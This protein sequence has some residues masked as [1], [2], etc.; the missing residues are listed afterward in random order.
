MYESR[1]SDLPGINCIW[2]AIAEDDGVFTD[3]ANEYWGLAFTKHADGIFSAELIGP[4]LMPRKLDSYRGEEYWGVEFK[5]HI[6]MRDIDKAAILGDMVQLPVRENMVC[7]HGKD[8]A[9]PLYDGLEALTDQLIRDGCIEANAHIL[10]SLKGSGAGFSER[11]WQRHFKRVTGITK[12]QIKQLERSRYAFFL[13]QQGMSAAV[14]ATEAGYA[15]QAHM[16]RSLKLIRSE[17]PAQ[18]IAQHVA[19]L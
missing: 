6:V 3:P 5:A 16:T 19:R 18:I 13:L 8:Y 9:I 17:T 12:K 11:S 2:H 4:T 7:L 1:S 10:Q 15:D 14:A